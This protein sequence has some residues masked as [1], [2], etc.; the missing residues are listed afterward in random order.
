MKTIIKSVGL[1]LITLSLSI[2][3]QAQQGLHIGIIGDPTNTWMLNSDDSD[4]SNHELKPTISAAFGL[5]IGYNFGD[6]MGIE[7][8][9]L[10]SLEGQRYEIGGVEFHQKNDYLKIPLMLTYNSD[11]S[12]SVMFLGKVG[13][14]L[15]V[16]VGSKLNDGDG[17]ELIDDTKDVF[18]ATTIGA[19]A[20]LGV[21]FNLSENLQL[22]T[23]LK[24]DYSFTNT[25]DEDYEFYDNNRATTNNMVG[26]LEVGLRYVIK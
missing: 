4:D 24:F 5:G 21:G 16:L 3:T 25:D 6:N 9:A 14:Q 23:G 22:T 13:P 1:L 12:A 10:Y 8:N 2:Q 11:P 7:V 20:S 26:G 18:A 15:G 17:N 19:A